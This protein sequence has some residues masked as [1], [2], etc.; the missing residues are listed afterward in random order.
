MR[1]GALTAPAIAALAA[2]CAATAPLEHPTKIEVVPRSRPTTTI[3]G[4]TSSQRA[5]LRRIL[6]GIGP[7]RVR[8]IQIAA[9]TGRDPNGPPHAV[10]VEAKANAHYDQLGAWQA[11]LVGR[12]FAR[13]SRQ[14]RLAPVTWIGDEAGGYAPY[15]PD[16]FAPL[17][18]APLRMDD[19]TIDLRR[20][21]EKAHRYGARVRVR[22]LRPDRLAFVLQ[23]RADDAADFLLNGLEPTLSWIESE[24]HDRY[25]G[26]YVDV[27]DARGKTVY[28]SGAGLMLSELGRSC[29]HYQMSSFLGSRPVP[30]CPALYR[31]S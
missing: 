4:G 22:I 26:L 6:A 30:P 14:L 5:L 18:K 23:F 2:G 31:G 20:V 1:L 28:A 16:L 10:A 8:S 3:V 11:D 29:A 12:V 25:D 24:D 13:R 19:A 21:V 7:N 27:T 17:G 15:R 9:D